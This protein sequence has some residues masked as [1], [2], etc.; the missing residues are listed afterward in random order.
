MKEEYKKLRSESNIRYWDKHRKPR[1]QK[2]GYMTIQIANQKYYIHRLVMEN[3]LGRKLEDYETVHH[4]NGGKTD[5]RIENLRLMSK[6]E[7]LRLHAK[8]NNLGKSNTGKEPINKTSIEIRK[9]IKELRNK[10]YLLKDICSITGLSYP[11][12][13]KYTKGA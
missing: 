4:I 13:I 8:E 9:Q 11:T 1:L 12:V 2:N 3:H 5:N 7:H 6:K 10:G